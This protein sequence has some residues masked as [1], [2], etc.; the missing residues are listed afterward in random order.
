MTAYNREEK[1]IIKKAENVARRHQI[2]RNIGVTQRLT[3]AK[4][5][6]GLWL[7]FGLL[8]MAIVTRIV[9]KLLAANPNNTFANFIYAFTDLF[10]WPFN[11]LLASPSSG[12]TVFEIS[13]IIAMLVYVIVAY[14]LTRLIWIVFYRPNERGVTTVE[15]VE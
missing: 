10:L 6:R 15:E 8:E 3:T 1:V 7:L 14:A 4:I 2:V 5:N 12:N 13:S 11:G 9:L